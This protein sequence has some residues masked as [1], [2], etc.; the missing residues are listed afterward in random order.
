M[1]PVD[2]SPHASCRAASKYP[3]HCC[4]QAASP[5]RSHAARVA[6]G[7]TTVVVVVVG[8]SALRVQNSTAAI[9]SSTRM[10]IGIAS[11]RGRLADDCNTPA[12]RRQTGSPRAI[13]RPSGLT[14][15][16]LP[17]HEAGELLLQIRVS[18]EQFEV[19]LAEGRQVAALAR[20]RVEGLAQLV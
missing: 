18:L 11:S 13:T 15:T 3:T 9:N 1:R 17:R 8:A 19:L 12:E 16:V 2:E 7:T 5:C 20:R 4:C 14:A 6:S 10:R